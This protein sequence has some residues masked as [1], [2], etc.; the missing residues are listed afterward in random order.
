MA[1]AAVG[2]VPQHAPTYRQPQK[3]PDG[4]KDWVC[5]YPIYINKD[6]TL[7]EGRRV[8]KSEAVKHPILPELMEAMQG[9]G[10]QVIGEP[11][12]IHPRE[13]SKEPYNY[14]RIR[15]EMKDSDGNIINEQFTR[16]EDIYRFIAQ[17]IPQ[18]KSRT[19][20]K[21]KQE[22]KKKGKGKKK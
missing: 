4:F 7:A 8:K 18:L 22:E 2:P 9:T 14:G 16:R 17:S 10:L 13:R 19:Q 20:P 11:N 3:L 1:T 12:R 5:V 21:Q 6:K 15:V